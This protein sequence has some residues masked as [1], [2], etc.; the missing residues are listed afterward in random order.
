MSRG[1]EGGSWHETYADSQWIFIGN[2]APSVTWQQVLVMFSQYGEIIDFDLKVPDAHRVGRDNT[3]YNQR[4]YSQSHEGV[5]QV[6]QS[7]SL[8]A[9]LKY[10]DARSCALAVD[11]FSGVE[12][13]ERRVKV[14]HVRDYRY[15]KHRISV[16]NG[17]SQLNVSQIELE[18]YTEGSQ[19]VED[20]GID[21]IDEIAIKLGLDLEDPMKEYLVQQH[22]DNLQQ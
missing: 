17:R 22:L 15:P 3:H 8:Y 18:N 12:L 14:D 16:S 20:D 2:L 11:N 9:Y 6:A 1:L 19:S 13:C 4:P 21:K 5:P 7:R 10:E